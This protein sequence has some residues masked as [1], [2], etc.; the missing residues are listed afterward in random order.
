MSLEI[1]K[2]G[3]KK[4][5]PTHVNYQ[6]EFWD[7]LMEVY[8][9]CDNGVYFAYVAG[10]FYEINLEI[11]KIKSFNDLAVKV[12]DDF[13]RIE[14]VSAEDIPQKTNP[15]IYQPVS[16]FSVY[17]ITQWPYSRVAKYTAILKGEHLKFTAPCNLQKIQVAAI[18]KENFKKVTGKN[19]WGLVDDELQEP[20]PSLSEVN[21]VLQS[22]CGTGLVQFSCAG[23]YNERPFLAFF[24]DRIIGN[25]ASAEAAILALMSMGCEFSDYG[26]YSL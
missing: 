26:E 20:G 19:P 8:I 12:L 23:F 16:D 21:R 24:K 9:W 2:I 13:F 11:D 22:Q 14:R 1:E 25:F 10:T 6:S 5:P 3:K 15:F 18:V 4:V 17:R 7:M